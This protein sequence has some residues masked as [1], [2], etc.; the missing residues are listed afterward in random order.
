MTTDTHIRDLINRLARLDS[1]AGWE[2]DL[3]PTQRAMLGYLDRA[4]RFSRSPSHVSDYLGITRGTTTQSLKSLRQKGYVNERRSDIDKRVVSYDLTQTGREAAAIPAPLE[5]SLSALNASDQQAL[6]QLLQN[7][8]QDILAKNDGREF[9]LCKTCRHHR[10]RDR[11][12]YCALLDV[13]LTRDE[14]HQICHEQVS[15]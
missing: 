9:G 4:N 1:A 7:M 3:N 14:P 13:A 11:G 15:A 5:E 2:G 12:P 10:E 8:L 6:R